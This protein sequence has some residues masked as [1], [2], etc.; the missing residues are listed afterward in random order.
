MPVPT[1]EK[2]RDLESLLRTLRGKNPR[3]LFVVRDCEQCKD[4]DRELQAALDD[5][6]SILYARFFHCVKIDRRVLEPSHEMNALFAGDGPPPHVL[7]VGNDGTTLPL[8]ADG[9]PRDLWAAMLRVLRADYTRDAALAVRD[10]VLLLD[11]FD[12]LDLREK[13]LL[14]QKT[15]ALA[16]PGK[17][18]RLASLD[19]DLAKV[20]QERSRLVAQETKLLD[21]GLRNVVVQP[22]IDFDAEAAAEVKSGAAGG[23][24]LDQ[25][26]KKEEGEKPP[27]KE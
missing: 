14:L 3:P 25:V 19:R 27:D 10:W 22:V 23:G 24:L 7:I 6:R 12:E 18:K 15:D 21:L 9:P 11:R 8:P 4:K 5:E 1:V 16:T 20:E 2:A 26:K 13:D 17:A